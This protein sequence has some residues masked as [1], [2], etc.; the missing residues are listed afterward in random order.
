MHFYVELVTAMRI[1]RNELYTIGNDVIWEI[2][3]G[4]YAALF[5]RKT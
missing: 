4:K 3:F 2:R 1:A 5:V